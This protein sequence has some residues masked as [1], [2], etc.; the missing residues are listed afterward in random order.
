VYGTDSMHVLGQDLSS[1]SSSSSVQFNGECRP[2]EE[3]PA[4]VQPLNPTSEPAEKSPAEEAEARKE[5]GN[6]LYK[7]RQWQVR[8]KSTFPLSFLK[9]QEVVA[10]SLPVHNGGFLF[11]VISTCMIHLHLFRAFSLN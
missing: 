4:D 1:V 6:E 10:R 7:E 11:P 2:N 8:T 5:R 9:E 3:H